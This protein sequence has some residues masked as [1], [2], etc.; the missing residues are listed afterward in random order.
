MLW[1]LLCLILVHIGLCDSCLA[2]DSSNDLRPTKPNS[3]GS[4]QTWQ[5]GF[6]LF[7][8]LIE[9]QGILPIRDANFVLEH[10]KESL[11][12]ALGA[13]KNIARQL[14]SF[15]AAGG[16][17]LYAFEFEMC[18]FPGLKVVTA[19]V[20]AT[21]PSLRY[22]AQRNA[23]KLNSID[24][25]HPLTFGIS[26][27]V[28]NRCGWL[29]PDAV[30]WQPLVWLPTNGILPIQSFGQA[31]AIA[32]GQHADVPIQSLI[33]ADSSMLSNGLIWH[34]DNVIFALNIVKHL[35]EGKQYVYFVVDGAPL[36]SY[37]DGVIA[38]DLPDSQLPELPPLDIEPPELT[39]REMLAIANSVLAKMEDTNFLNEK[40]VNQPQ[41]LTIWKFR[42]IA[43]LC[44]AAVW[45]LFMGYFLL[46]RQHREYRRVPVN[47]Q[48]PIYAFDKNSQTLK[49]A[50]RQLCKEFC[51]TVAGSAEPTT[52]KSEDLAARL[53]GLGISLTSTELT[54]LAKIVETAKAS[55][56]KGKETPELKLICDTIGQLHSKLMSAATMS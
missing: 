11:I 33:L 5:Y 9:H 40:L 20:G 54:L 45:L 15:A 18:D 22:Q 6:D 49:S 2:Q 31:V 13:N 16:K 4:S 36:G 24:D 55:K 7:R 25:N 34:G 1:R 51:E 48:Q 30:H 8:S 42:R 47:I 26:S 38:R 17:Y 28:V 35:G 39:G 50:A 56:R 53:Q 44:A 46:T 23:M 12:V 14:P 41:G 10:P 21:N 29:M 3:K 37:R 52:W 27:L 19:T 32:N 43:L